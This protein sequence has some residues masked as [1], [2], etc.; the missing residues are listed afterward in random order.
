MNQDFN[1]HV[2]STSHST[3]SDDQETTDGNGQSTGNVCR[4][5]VTRSLSNMEPTCNTH[6]GT[7]TG[8]QSHA[9]ALPPPQAQLQLQPA[10]SS[11]P[12]PSFRG[13]WS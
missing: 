8:P 3:A 2:S 6:T 11:S 5:S 13:W 12:S 10:G 7:T 4:S 9:S 1:L